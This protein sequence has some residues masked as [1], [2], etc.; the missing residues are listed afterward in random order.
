MRCS[1]DT[2]VGVDAP[3]NPPAT[4]GDLTAEANDDNARTAGDK[5]LR[6]KGG[7]MAG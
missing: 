6:W 2:S 3:P 7:S 1:V 4:G 5:D